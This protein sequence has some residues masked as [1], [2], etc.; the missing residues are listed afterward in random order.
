M[1]GLFLVSG[2]GG[3]TGGG[4]SPSALPVQET[5]AIIRRMCL[6]VYRSW[7]TGEEGGKSILL[8]INNGIFILEYGAVPFGGC[9]CHAL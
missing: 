4:Y 8:Q 6:F 3:M 5:G 7:E 9:V 1:P 2:G